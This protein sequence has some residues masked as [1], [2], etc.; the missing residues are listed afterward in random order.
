MTSVSGGLPVPEGEVLIDAFPESALRYGEGFAVVAVDVLRATTTA[1]TAV[2]SGRRCFVAETVDQAAV[3][4]R[5]LESPIMAGEIGGNMPFGFEMNNSPAEMAQRTDVQ[6]PVVL[7][8]SSGTLLIRNAA[9]SGH[10]YL[11]CFR[12]V[13]PTVRFL[14]TRYPRIAVV[15][16]GSRGEFREEDQ[17]CCA[18]VA[19]RLT[20]LGYEA[21]S[22]ETRECLERWSGVSKDAWLG[23]NSVRFLLS[24]GQERDVEFVLAHRNDLDA[25]FRV[26]GNEVLQVPAGSSAAAQGAVGTGALGAAG[27]EP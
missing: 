27:G 3:I 5:E 22:P 23:S 19:G 26:D 17:M 18:R 4:G 20:E 25:V 8:T 2:A 1:V 15:G 10:A 9:R 7:V 6:R 12:N 16:A 11:A 13:E 24:T 14:A 21:A